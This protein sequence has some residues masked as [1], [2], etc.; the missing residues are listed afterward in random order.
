LPAT[1]NENDDS[2]KAATISRLAALKAKRAAKEAVDG[3]T[4]DIQA[5][6]QADAKRIRLAQAVEPGRLETERLTREETAVKAEADYVKTDHTAQDKAESD[7][8]EA[9]RLAKEKPEAE[10][11]AKIQ[12]DL[13]SVVTEIQELEEQE[14]A[15]ILVHDEVIVS[16][17]AELIDAQ[18]FRDTVAG[19]K[20]EADALVKATEK[21]LAEVQ[22]CRDNLLKKAA[23]VQGDLDEAQA[24]VNDTEKGLAD[25]TATN[26]DAAYKHRQ[27]IQDLVERR[28]HLQQILEYPEV[29]IPWLLNG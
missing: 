19:D 27:T 20:A 25:L 12:A 10:R 9:E 15:R 22:T 13:D 8:L 4:G 5:T 21:E 29:S 26:D 28:A 24:L 18:S 6:A 17:K 14:Q 1:N 23:D 3:N 11:R 7:H 16:A 2:L